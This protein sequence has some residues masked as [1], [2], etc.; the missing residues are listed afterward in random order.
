M[1]MGRWIIGLF[2]IA[3]VT[4]ARAEQPSTKPTM[5]PYHCRWTEKP[6]TIDGKADEEAWRDAVV[7]EDFRAWWNEGDEQ[8]QHTTT[9]AKLL[10]DREYLYFFAKME[11]HDL[12]AN[13]K[14]HQGNLWEGDVFELFFKPA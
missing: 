7:I 5:P 8:K 14:E 3:L 1:S 11:D 10:W 13:T 12:Y 9:K 4:V 6:I 2:C